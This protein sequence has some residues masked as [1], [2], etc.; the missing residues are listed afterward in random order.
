M[1]YIRS[2][3]CALTK[4]DP[5]FKRAQEFQA[6]LYFPVLGAVRGRHTHSLLLRE[7]FLVQ[8]EWKSKIVIVSITFIQCCL[9][10][11]WMPVLILLLKAVAWWCLR[12]FYQHPL[13]PLWSVWSL[14]R[15]LKQW[16][17]WG[18]YLDRWDFSELFVQHGHIQPPWA[19][20]VHEQIS[21]VS[22]PL[23]LQTSD[24]FDS[25]FRSTVETIVWV[26]VSWGCR[27]LVMEVVWFP[28]TQHCYKYK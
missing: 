3:F 19:H 13:V 12:H 14:C 4:S 25:L 9:Q 16:A 20:L 6:R 24:K 8:E 15:Y 11:F 17:V 1:N 7:A 26:A 22:L 2:I 18:G 28:G 5:A 10:L 27:L 23:L 21:I